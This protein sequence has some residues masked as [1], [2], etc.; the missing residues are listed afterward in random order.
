MSDSGYVKIKGVLRPEGMKAP[1]RASF[2]SAQSGPQMASRFA[3]ANNVSPNQDNNEVTRTQIRN[4]ARYEAQNST[5]AR[6]ITLTVANDTIGTGPRLQ[7]LSTSKSLNQRVEA[8][9]RKWSDQVC[10]P[11]KLRLMRS[12]RMIDGEV[13]AE[14]VTNENAQNKVKLDISLYEADFLQSKWGTENS[15]THYDGID[16]DAYG[17]PSRYWLLPFHPGDSSITGFSQEKP[18]AHAAQT[19][20][21]YF[22][23]DRAGQRRG[24]SEIQSALELFNQLRTYTKA[25]LDAAETAS[26]HAGLLHTNA[27]ADE[28]AD[29]VNAF[30][31]FDL[32]RNM[33]KALP[34]GW[35]F[36]QLKAE[37]PTTSY[38]AFKHE[39]INE[40]ARCVNVPFNIAALNSSEYNYASGRLDH[41]TYFRAI[42]VEQSVIEATILDKIFGSW[43]FEYGLL[44]GLTATD[45]INHRWYWDGRLHVDPL[46]EAEAQSVRLLNNTT[47]LAEEYGSRGED[48]EAA[49]D[50]RAI[51]QNKLIELGLMQD[52]SKGMPDA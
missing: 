48:W 40:I 39:I 52:P 17:N 9:F 10:L 2:D 7:Y 34:F 11:E 8:D 30:Y 33:A 3:Y 19:I 45:R 12:S 14:L 13:L 37:Q 36:R 42:E 16:Y 4:R 41:Q 21:H 20:I 15:K 6:G 18:V 23:T 32:T 49:L 31:E 27:P 25:T 5:Y 28:V 35:D 43:I 22:R 44:Q 38:P 26:N 47:T 24:V 51:E 29:D 46:K 50:Q 1:V